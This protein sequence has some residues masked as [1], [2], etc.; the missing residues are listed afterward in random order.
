MKR[1][2]LFSLSTMFCLAVHSQQCEGCARGWAIATES[3]CKMLLQNYGQY[4][5]ERLVNISIPSRQNGNANEYIRLKKGHLYWMNTAEGNFVYDYK[6]EGQYLRLSNKRTLRAKHPVAS[7]S[8]TIEM[9]KLW[10]E[11]TDW[12]FQTV[13]NN[14]IY[15]LYRVDAKRK[16]SME[17]YNYH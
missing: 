9:T 16:R 14:G 12:Y 3:K 11:G 2:L 4:Q 10:A 1:L 7:D 17:I 6:V 13:D 5:D 15:R 8:L